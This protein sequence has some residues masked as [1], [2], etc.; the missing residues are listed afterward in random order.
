[1]QW[2]HA[3]GQRP[4]C[5]H[6]ADGVAGEPGNGNRV[7]SRPGGRRGRCRGSKPVAACTAVRVR[8]LSARGGIHK[9]QWRM[10]AVEAD[11][12]H[13]RPLRVGNGRQCRL[14]M[15]AAPAVK[16]AVQASAHT[17]ALV[18]TRPRGAAVRT[19]RDIACKGLGGTGLGHPTQLCD[20]PKGT[21]AVDTPTGDHRGRQEPSHRQRRGAGK[22]VAIQSQSATSSKA[23][24]GPAG[25]WNRRHRRFL[26]SCD[27]IS[28]FRDPRSELQCRRRMQHATGQHR[29]T[30]L[31]P[32]PLG[33]VAVPSSS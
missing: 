26:Q 7:D 3:L 22:R 10:R 9:G 4:G 2:L 18:S 33:A 23:P 1:M 30:S 11:D 19:G 13:Q 17:S 27:R 8:L 6:R 31:V 29:P 14:C 16:A 12:A 28:G 32:R 25:S 21:P 15:L 24:L 20:G 5:Q